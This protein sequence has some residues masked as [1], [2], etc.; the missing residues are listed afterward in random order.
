M[1]NPLPGVQEL[2]EQTGV[3]TT[4][5]YDDAKAIGKTI[6]RYLE[7]EDLCRE[8]FHKARALHLDEYNYERQMQP[9]LEKIANV[10]QPH[11]N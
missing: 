8:V 11:A 6:S 2:F 10:K 4:A 9:L 1:T 5:S 3:A 7:N